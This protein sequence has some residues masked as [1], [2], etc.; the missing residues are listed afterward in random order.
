MTDL[1][2][3][4]AGEDIES[5]Y[6][7]DSLDTQA[8]LTADGG[9]SKK[10]LKAGSGW[11]TPETGDQ[12]FVH[13]TGTLQSD[14]SKF[15]SSLDRQE[16]FK[17][18]LGKG[19]VIKG[20]DEGVKTMKKGEKAMLTISPEYGYGEQGSP[21][22]IPPNATLQ[23]EVE[24][25][26][27]HSVKDITPTK[28]GGIIKTVMNEG[29]GWAMPKDKD[30]VLVRYKVY[31]EDKSQ[32]LK[33]S[34]ETGA[35]FVLQEG[36]AVS[37]LPIVLK[38]MKK[39]EKASLLLKAGYG[40]SGDSPQHA[41]VELLSWKQVK[42][43][44]SDGGV[45]KK[46]IKESTEYKTATI[47]S[48]VKV[49]LMGKLSDGTVFADHQADDNLLRFLVG[50]EQVCLG[51]EEA[52]QTMKLNE[53]AEV[54]VQ[55]QYGFG[56]QEHQLPQATVPADSILF[57]NVELVELSKPKEGYEMANPE[58]LEEAK[59]RKDAGNDLFKQGMWAR[60][61]K[62][63]KK[64][65]ELIEHDD[66]FSSDEKKV[67]ADMKKSCNL[68]LAATYLNI[69]DSKEARK[70]CN[71]VLEKDPDNVK[72]L[73]RRAQAYMMTQDYIE[74]KQD[75]SL[76]IKSEPT[77]RDMR[78]LLK[79]LKAEQSALDKKEASMYSKV[80]QRMAQTSG[81]KQGKTEEAASNMED[82]STKENTAGQN[83]AAQTAAQ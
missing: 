51:L 6:V 15:D 72:A 24:L 30:E 1:Q 41:E 28:D 43:I 21:P 77:N 68:N 46:V 11:E 29:D 73:F 25:L 79:K 54:V 49:R 61:L 12:V 33:E 71:K 31:N 64:G 50:E 10:I 44:T 26:S 83:S 19:Q 3:I 5:K 8:A 20:W 32:V 45:I 40:L 55:P 23:F 18:D 7:G 27:W 62:K 36:V 42:D 66:Q 53:V 2:G 81:A 4:D 37:A 69:N 16:P 52:V 75:L 34:P 14:G 57:Y 76:A 65:M 60:A 82:A 17:F 63:Y 48:T 22:T 78:A 80:F 70:A 13:Y 9:V 74:A 38:T 58:K 39:G 47:E 35:E 67:S 59:K 56:S